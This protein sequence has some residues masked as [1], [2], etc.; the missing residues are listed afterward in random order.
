MNDSEPVDYSGLPEHMQDVAK[1]YIELGTP[2]GGFLEAVLCNRLVESFG[3]ADQINR[4]AMYAWTTWLWNEAPMGSWGTPE[5]V[6]AWIA[7]GGLR[8]NIR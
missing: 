3:K 8:G 6:D 5:K 2:P 4:L 7:K 1:L